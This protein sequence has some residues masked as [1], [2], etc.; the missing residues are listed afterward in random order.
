MI[1]RKKKYI[2]L[3]SRTFLRGHQREGQQTNFAELIKQ[4]VKLH[5]IRMNYEHWTKVKEK[6]DKGEALLSIR[7]WT[8]SPYRS[9]QEEIMVLEKFDI[10]RIHIAPDH[11][12]VVDGRALDRYEGQKLM[13]N[14][15][16]LPEDFRGWFPMGTTHE[17][18][19]IHF[20]NL[21]RY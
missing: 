11:S 6:V 2:L 13:T 4:G 19:I 14:D 12:I 10:Q 1:P 17:G 7:Y 18:V 15:G 16:L 3:V 20:S 8:G 21:V 5:T 9:T